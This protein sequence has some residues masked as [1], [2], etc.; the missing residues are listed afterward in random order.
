MFSAT[1]KLGRVFQCSSDAIH[2]VRRSVDFSGRTKARF[3]AIVLCRCLPFRDANF[4]A[5]NEQRFT[6]RPSSH[7]FKRHVVNSVS[8]LVHFRV[9][10]D[11]FQRV[12]VRMRADVIRS[13]SCQFPLFSA[14]VEHVVKRVRSRAIREDFSVRLLRVRLA[15][16]M[17]VTNIY[18]F[19]LHV[20][21]FAGHRATFLVRNFLL[22]L[23]LLNCFGARL[24]NV[25]DSAIFMFPI[26]R[27][28]S[29]LSFKSSVSR[30]GKLTYAKVNL[31]FMRTARF[32]V[33]HCSVNELYHANHVS[34]L[35][36]E[37]F[38][39][40]HCQRKYDGVILYVL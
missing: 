37:A 19:C 26:F 15:I 22:R 21:R 16:L 33:R 34:R 38:L 4:K 25:S 5:S 6:G 1:I 11:A 28:S 9:P 24:F 36:S 30:F 31:R 8:Q 27:T 10:S 17:V 20:A 13:A 35:T 39:R 23:L 40:F 3:R 18:R 29:R 32:K 12:S 14:S 7:V 2:L